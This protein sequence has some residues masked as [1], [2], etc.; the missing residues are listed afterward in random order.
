MT[1]ISWLDSGA[2]QFIDVDATLS[3]AHN[4]EAEVT[5]EPVEAGANA[6]DNVR[7]KPRTLALELFVA[8]N[9]KVGGAVA[10][11]LGRSERI[12]SWFERFEKDGTRLTI[13]LGGKFG[14]GRVY[15]NMV[16]Q[17][18]RVTRTAKERDCLTISA[19]F[20]EIRIANSEI[21]AVQAAKDPKGK[22]KIT[23]GDQNTK[24]VGSDDDNRSLLFRGF[25]ALGVISE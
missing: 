22:K 10:F 21:V 9:Y 19:T 6:S 23:G 12:F 11:E 13:T 16:V 2:L 7:A 14:F 20:K 15:E 25:S 4:S 5:D 17:S 3:E 1:S 8:D 18:A 24:P